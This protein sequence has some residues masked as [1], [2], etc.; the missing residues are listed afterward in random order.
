MAELT[1]YTVGGTV[2]AGGGVYL[3]RQADEELL[4]LCRDRT[5]AYILAPR[6]LGKSSLM[7]STAERLS[8]EGIQ[9][10]IVDLTKLGIQVTAENWYLGFLVEIADQLMLDADLVEWW[11][12]CPCPRT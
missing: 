7:V 5:F 9:S 6:Q 3:P 2:Q 1:I 4:A 11:Q 12:C 8:D 10:V